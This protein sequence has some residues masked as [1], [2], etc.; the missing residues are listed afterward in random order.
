[1][2]VVSIKKKDFCGYLK[3]L[4]LVCINGCAFVNSKETK[5]FKKNK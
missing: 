2:F 1:M 3:V 5:K 4:F